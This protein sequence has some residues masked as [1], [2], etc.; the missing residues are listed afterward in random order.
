MVPH[1]YLTVCPGY[2]TIHARQYYYYPMRKLNKFFAAT[3]LAGTLSTSGC[4]D[5]CELVSRNEDS[6]ELVSAAEVM[7]Y[8]DR[9]KAAIVTCLKMSETG[10]K[11]DCS[12]PGYTCNSF[13]LQ[14]KMDELFNAGGGLYCVEDPAELIVNL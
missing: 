14:Q 8:C 11:V 3:A 10:D 4:A 6:P 9:N 1:N 13:D 2:A 7:A 12:A 5:D